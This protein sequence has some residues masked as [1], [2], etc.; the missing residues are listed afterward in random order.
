MKKARVIIYRYEGRKRYGYALKIKE[1]QLK[2]LHE[3]FGDCEIYIDKYR[4]A[5][6]KAK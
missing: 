4:V 1:S 5:I 6:T 3:I 2:H